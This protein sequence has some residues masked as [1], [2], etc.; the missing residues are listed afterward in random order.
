[1]HEG[2]D[3]EIEARS[4]DYSIGSSLIYLSFP[5]S[6]AEEAYKKVKDLA[7]KHGLGFFNVSNQEKEIIF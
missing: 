1:M 6:L 7:V 3:E 2:E 5:W 4:V